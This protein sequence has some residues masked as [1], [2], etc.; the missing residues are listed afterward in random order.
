MM[1]PL[2]HALMWE[3]K[4]IAW[5]IYNSGTINIHKIM[6]KKVMTLFLD[7]LFPKGDI[8]VHIERVTKDVLL[9]KLTI[10]TVLNQEYATAFFAYKDSDIKNMIWALKYYRKKDIAKM[11]AEIM[12]ENILEDLSDDMPITN[13]SDP[14]LV[15]IPLS[16]K[17][18]RER[19]FNQSELLARG[20][21]ELDDSNFFSLDTEAL[22]KVKDEQHQA[23]TSEKSD[24]LENI[25]GS[26]VVRVPE[27]IKGRN[28]II[29]DDV[30]TTGATVSEACRVLLDASAKEVRAITVAH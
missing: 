3:C 28:I 7:F 29:V 26:F 1:G 11:F 16:K 30:I 5:K 27:N 17:R 19:G 20:I 21:V 22:L 2:Y 25:K 18:L 15:P 13:F 6:L 8:D 14:L 12:Y 10:Q 4:N 9:E 23:H 24:R